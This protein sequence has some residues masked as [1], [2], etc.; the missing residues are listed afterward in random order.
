[1]NYILVILLIIT[2]LIDIFLLYFSVTRKDKSR[3][4]YL[5]VITIATTLYALGNILWELS[6]T[7][8]G[9]MNALIVANLGIPLLAPCFFLISICLFQPKYLKS[10]MMPAVLTYGLLVFFCVMFNDSH[11]LYY[12]KVDVE[13]V[14]PIV[15]GTLFYIQQAIGLLCMIFAYI[16]LFRRFIKG[17]KK[18]RL[19]MIYIIIGALIAFMANIANIV[20]LI[21]EQIDITPFVMTVALTFFTVNIAKYKL[22][23]II[24]IASDTAFESME[25]A[26]IIVDNDW[27]FLFCNNNAKLL[28]PSLEAF[29]GTEPVTKIKDWPEELQAADKM[30]EIVFEREGKT[31][32]S[33]KST[34]RANISPI[35]DGHG[36]RI[37]WS[38]IICNTTSMTF[39][40]TQLEN[41]ATTDPLTG[42]ANRRHFLE[43]VNQELEM[44][45]PYRLN[46]SSALIMY[47]LDD[48]KKV[49]DTYGHA[50]GDH[51]LCS[52]VEII[53]KSLRLYDIIC[54][55]GGEEFV[56]F[57]PATNE[58]ILYQ[59]AFRLC[60][61]IE[62]AEIVYKDTRIPITASFG[63]V[64]M[65]PGADFDK[66]MLAV[67]EAMYKAK[68]NGKNQV[69]IGHIKKDETE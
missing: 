5:V 7:N 46:I 25:D 26:V 69:I 18:L 68:K 60:K 21:P 28:F 19:Q 44:S 13:A 41:L 3:S 61:E 2:F 40:I 47:D 31:A 11:L 12:T 27:C 55:Y 62:N 45:A 10:W 67:D 64:H 50:A 9:A 63:A 8:N 39:L 48:F 49:N 16:L 34:Y 56:I 22:M 35:A 6:V 43:R 57:T 38:I 23:D 15:H 33:Q 29:L 4:V 14:R 66:A 65:P 20:G 59:L 54:R 42:V 51:I 30:T 53:K 17:N 32:Y 36:V 37:G 58:N 52:V 24:S 1:M